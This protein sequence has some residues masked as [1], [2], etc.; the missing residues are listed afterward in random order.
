MGSYEQMLKFV[1]EKKL[2]L[3]GIYILQKRDKNLVV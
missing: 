3:K 1:A 2:M